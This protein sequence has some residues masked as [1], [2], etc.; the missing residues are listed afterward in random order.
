MNCITL[1]R[2]APAKPRPG[3]PCNGCGVCCALRPCPLGMLLFR[4]RRGAC[5]ALQWQADAGHYR[6]GLLLAPQQY[7][8][9]LP[10]CLLPAA[11]R[12]TQRLIAAGQGCDCD[13]ELA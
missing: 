8:P 6:C 2:D 13:V 3:A 1:Q 10:T 12:Y 7:L 11:R 5:P 4:Q 9:A